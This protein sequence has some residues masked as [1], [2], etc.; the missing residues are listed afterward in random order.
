MCIKND[1]QI[2]LSKGIPSALV[3]LDLSA[4]FDTIDHKILL[5]CLS[6]W[7]G[8][9]GTV[10]DWFCSYLSGRSQQVKVGS[11]LSDPFKLTC[12]VPQGSVLGPILFSMYTAPLSSVISAYG[13]TNH[14]FYADDTQLYIQLSPSNFITAMAKLQNCLLVV[15]DWM[16]A[17]K[18]KLNPD[19][20]EFIVIG[21]DRQRES[22]SEFF[23][24]DIL[25]SSLSPTDK[26]RNLGV[27]FDSAFS[28][29]NQIVSVC[30]SCFVGLRDLRR[31]KRYLSR[32]SA[33]I[34]AKALVS[35][36]LDYCNSLYR[37]LTARDLRRLQCVQ[38]SLARIVT[39]TPRR[40]HITPVLK[41]LHWLPIKYRSI[42]KTSTIVYKFLKTGL[43]RYFSPYLSPYTSAVNTRR[44]DTNKMYLSKPTFQ[45]IKGASKSHFSKSFAYDAP[46]TWND[47][48]LDVRTAPSVSSFRSRLKA[49]LFSKAFPP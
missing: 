27:V 29:S 10:L 9:K 23:P 45:P 5:R 47:L 7:F 16:K 19:K 15:Q 39:N 22:L 6:D 48:P 30:K 33:V 17:A 12:G 4:A 46:D 18:L 32:S 40:S 49:Y 25:G 26:V 21:S 14:H 41:S 34:L 31:I 11:A 37:G 1:I 8:L 24:V 13:N 28:F 44:S 42:F 36:K 38:N 43:P 2:S 3:L 20:T 35:S